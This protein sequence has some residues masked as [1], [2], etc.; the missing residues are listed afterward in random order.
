MYFTHQDQDR[1]EYT[2]LKDQFLHRGD[3]AALA[4]AK[5]ALL[6]L[7]ALP[8]ISFPEDRH[9]YF[10]DPR[11]I[12]H[13]YPK[14]HLRGLLPWTRCTK[15]KVVA[16]LQRKQHQLRGRH[17]ALEST[18]TFTL[19]SPTESETLLLVRAESPSVW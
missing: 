11:R 6:R 15:D 12:R 7:G 16:L 2:P 3:A 13:E 10:D 1:G 14:V 17:A 4:A 9:R 19:R 8:S 5:H 18:T